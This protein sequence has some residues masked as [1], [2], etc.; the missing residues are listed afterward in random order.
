MSTSKILVF[1]HPSYP[2][3]QT[4][5]YVKDEKK[6]GESINVFKF[7]IF[8]KLMNKWMY[9]I[10]KINKINGSS[11]NFT[12]LIQCYGV[13]AMYTMGVPAERQSSCD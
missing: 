2:S 9:I 5:S 8:I 1:D 4:Q 7:C 6:I 10:N 12:H 13:I 11:S 3:T